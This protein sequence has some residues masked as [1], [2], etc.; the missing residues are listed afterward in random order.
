MLDSFGFR[1]GQ[2]LNQ[3]QAPSNQHQ[4][5]Q[6]QQMHQPITHHPPQPPKRNEEIAYHE[7]PTNNRKTPNTSM[8]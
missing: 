6:A 1:S 3:N 8:E 4:M 7:P 5:H 2:P